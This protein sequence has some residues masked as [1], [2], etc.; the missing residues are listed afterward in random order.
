MYLTVRAL[1]SSAAQVSERK[2]TTFTYDDNFSSCYLDDFNVFDGSFADND[3]GANFFMNC[4]SSHLVT[5]SWKPDTVAGISEPFPKGQ[6]WYRFCFV[7]FHLHE[8][9][10]KLSNKRGDIRH[11][12]P[13]EVL[14][15]SSSLL[16]SCDN[17]GRLQNFRKGAWWRCLS[18]NHLF[19][20]LTD[21][22]FFQAPAIL[23]LQ[24]PRIGNPTS[25]L[26]AASTFLRFFS[27]ALFLSWSRLA[28]KRFTIRCF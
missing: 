3:H 17:W 19:S 18:A 4:E 22:S 26:H 10:L 25:S 2:L 20:A 8:L 27:S 16:R 23:S 14:G 5:P 1:T 6:H 7:E 12:V 24:I 13:I 28:A 9:C 21:P 15:P 11:D